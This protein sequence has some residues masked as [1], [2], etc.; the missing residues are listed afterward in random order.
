MEFDVISLTFNNNG[1]YYVIPVVADPI[2]I[3]NDITPPYELPEIDLLK[4][5]L[6]I[7][8]LILIV[9]LLYPFLPMVFNI[10]W[11]IIKVVFKFVFRLLSLPFI[12]LKSLFK[13]RK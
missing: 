3:I 9:V 5:I 10:I 6:G 13:K 4:I 11:A 8:L 12:L 1:V 2:N 7:L